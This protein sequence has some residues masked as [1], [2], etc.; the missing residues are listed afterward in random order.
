MHL[1]RLKILFITLLTCLLSTIH[2]QDSIQNKQRPKFGAT[3]NV[4]AGLFYT[5]AIGFVTTFRDSHQIEL[6]G[7]IIP[8]VNPFKEKMHFG[9]SLNYNFLPNRADKL[10]NLLF[11][12][13]I[14]FTN[15]SYVNEYTAW[16][17]I[18][19]NRSEY[20]TSDLTLLVGLGFDAKITKRLHMSFSV[21]NYLAS[22]GFS[23]YKYID[24]V[25]NTESNNS[26]K[27]WTLLEPEDFLVNDLLAKIGIVYYFKN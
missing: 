17:N 14:Y 10:L 16:P 24:Y 11:T 25:N 12:S 18:K 21:S 23:K 20:K 26:Y 22:F 19:Q 13:S 9:S 6:N 4:N 7:L 15:Y 27:S 3:Y 1:T 8:G 2:S 5:H